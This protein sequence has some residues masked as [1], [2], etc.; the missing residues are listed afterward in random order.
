MSGKNRTIIKILRWLLLAVIPFLMM[1]FF[2][3]GKS[4][5]QAQ[6]PLKIL[7]VYDHE[8]TPGVVSRTQ[9]EGGTEYGTA[10]QWGTKAVNAAIEG[11]LKA[12]ATEILV[13]DG[14]GSKET[15][16]PDMLHKDALLIRGGPIA[17]YSMAHGATYPGVDAIMLVSFH[18]RAGAPDAVLCHTITGN[19]ENLWVNDVLVGETGYAAAVAGAVNIPI[20]F[21]SGDRALCKEAQSLLGGDLEAAEVKW[22]EPGAAMMVTCLH[23]EKANDIIRKKAEAAVEKFKRGVF[24]PYPVKKPT[25][26]KVQLNV[27]GLHYWTYAELAVQIP[28]VKRVDPTTVSFTGDPLEA[29]NFVR[30]LASNLAGYKK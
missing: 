24:K 12:G 15:I 3:M 14:H 25:T 21:V 6:K 28:G 13:S 19:I 23:P 16:L 2:I 29:L 1:T 11:A 5:V 7:I 4:D 26:V 22:I 10:R 8:G 18:A 27:M 20:I 17:P 9:T 30:V